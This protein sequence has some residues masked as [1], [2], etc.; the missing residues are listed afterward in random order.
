[1]TRRRARSAGVPLNVFLFFENL[2]PVS[3]SHPPLLMQPEQVFFG[4][5]FLI[6]LRSHAWE[7]RRGDK[8][9][10]LNNRE[11]LEE[12]KQLEGQSTRAREEKQTQARTKQSRSVCQIK[13]RRYLPMP[14]E[15]HGE[16]MDY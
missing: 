1:M 14:T 9:M 4:D 8:T 5:F 6:L 16:S 13:I 7:E 12:T 3:L 10:V 11:E 15:I 2:S